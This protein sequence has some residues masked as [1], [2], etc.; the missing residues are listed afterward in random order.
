[1]SGKQKQRVGIYAGTFDPVHSGH[2][3]FALQSL[4][5]ANLDVI[6]FVPE[7]RPRDKR[8][9]EHF[10]HRVAMIKRAIR[11]HK[12]FA[13]LELVESSFSVERTL[14][15]LNEHFSGDELVFLFGSDI[16]PGLAKWPNVDKLLTAHE[17]VIGLRNQDNRSKLHSIIEAWPYQ[18]K[19]VTMFPSYAPKVSSGQVREALRNHR[20]VE[21]LLKSVERYSDHHWLYVTLA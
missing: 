17:L 18:P 4:A 1:M 19:A 16:V 21:G 10:A 8:H 3:S 2:I 5:A 6:Y 11:P 20:P 7:R 15:R 13:V 9:I 14:P 12:K